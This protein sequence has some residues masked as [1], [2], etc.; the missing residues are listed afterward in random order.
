MADGE[1]SGSEGAAYFEFRG[2]A[3]KETFVIM[4]VHPEQIAHA[5]RILSGEEK[6]LIHAQ[7][8]IVQQRAAYNPKWNYR[9]RPDSISFLKIRLRFAMEI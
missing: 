5:R 4:L 3:E 1:K 6:S 7:G 2:S 9:L 8:M